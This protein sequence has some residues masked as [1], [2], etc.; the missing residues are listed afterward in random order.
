MRT[1][2]LQD[3]VWI[4]RV[5]KNLSDLYE[6]RPL[7][8][9]PFEFVPYINI[10]SKLEEDA[11]SFKARKATVDDMKRSY[12][13]YELAL[14]N[15][16]KDYEQRTTRGFQDD[17]VFVIIPLSGAQGWFPEFFGGINEWQ[18]NRPPFP[19]PLVNNISQLDSLKPDISK[20]ELFRIGIEQMRYF[21]KEVG[22]KIPVGTP[23]IQSPVDFASMLIDY[24]NLIYMMVDYPQKVH[25]LMRMITETLISSLHLMK[26]EM[27]ADWPITQFSW[28][29]PK[30]VF[31][32][33]DLMAVL[34]P[35]L[36]AEFGVPYNEIIAEEFGGIALHSC[37]NIKH[38]LENVA[39]TK[40][41]IAL[42][43][44]ETLTTAAAALK[45]RVSVITG[46][47]REIMA[48]NYPGSL[49]DNLATGKE[50]EEFWWRD[51]NHLPEIKGQRFLYQCHALCK[52]R[53]P[54]EAY[55]KML[56]FSDRLVNGNNNEAD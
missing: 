17:S 13:D 36:Y 55:Q 9:M 20:G 2:K 19:H 1:I 33:D 34:S 52:D 22:D 44:H 21:I 23:D 35:E 49:R 3:P 24:T 56:G 50:V 32:S 8:R 14:Q 51:F 42:N 12:Y 25:Q 30:G 18:P 29:M 53:A 47:V 39:K 10:S 28:W 5:K 41:I 46:A 26:K 45:D 4:E 16:L 11:Q 43:T 48:P 15:Q 54:E 37:G 38:N 7:T 27:V 6:R 40:G 31:L